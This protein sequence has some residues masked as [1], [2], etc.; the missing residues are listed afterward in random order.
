VGKIAVYV[1]IKY[2]EQMNSTY[3][4]RGANI[5]DIITQ[6]SLLSIKQKELI[7]EYLKDALKTDKEN[8]PEQIKPIHPKTSTIEELMRLYPNVNFSGFVPRNSD[9]EKYQLWKLIDT[10]GDVVKKIGN[11]NFQKLRITL[12]VFGDKI[13]YVSD[14]SIAINYERFSKNDLVAQLVSMFRS[15]EG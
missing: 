3:E 2:N 6:I 12:T 14:G 7:L 15:Q 9:K 10:F 1:S 8:E 13:T 11:D 4:D 5:E